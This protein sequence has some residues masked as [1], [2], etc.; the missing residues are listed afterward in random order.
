M[1]DHRAIRITNLGLTFGDLET[2]VWTFFTVGVPAVNFQRCSSFPI[3]LCSKLATPCSNRCTGFEAHWVRTA[4]GSNCSNCDFQG[5]SCVTL[6]TS[7]NNFRFLRLLSLRRFS[8]RRLS[9]RRL[10]GQNAS[11]VQRITGSGRSHTEPF[12]HGSHGSIAVFDRRIRSTCSIDVFDRQDL[13]RSG[14]E[15]ALHLPHLILR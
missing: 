12:Q 1:K 15:G 9:L 7:D 10:S 2:G 4:L 8:L 6:D 11:S 3:K 13:G 14:K 5:D